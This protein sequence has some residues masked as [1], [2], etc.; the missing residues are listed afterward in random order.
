MRV[1]LLC[2]TICRT[3]LV[4]ATVCESTPGT[5]HEKYKNMKIVYLVLT[6]KDAGSVDRCM[7]SVCRSICPVVLRF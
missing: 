5:K 6:K 7:R 1:L 3:H 4:E 2:T